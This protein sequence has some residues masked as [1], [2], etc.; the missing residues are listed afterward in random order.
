[1]DDVGEGLCPRLLFAQ[2]HTLEDRKYIQDY[3]DQT[4][5]LVLSIPE[6]QSIN[7]RKNVPIS[8]ESPQKIVRL[9]TIFYRD[10]SRKE[11]ILTDFPFT[12]DEFIELEN[13]NRKVSTY[14]D[15][16]TPDQY[17]FE[18]SYTPATY[19]LETDRLLKPNKNN[20][21]ASELS[22]KVDYWIVSGAIGSGKTTVAK[23]I[24]NEFGFKMIEFET[25]L[26]AAKE[27]LANPDEG[28]EVPLK[29]ILNYFKN[30]LVQNKGTTCI[31]DGLT[32]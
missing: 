20:C 30:L 25:E 12:L 29:K 10:L 2:C 8:L 31:I 5:G 7:K 1:M 16:S 19:F 23:H 32:Y 24:Q 15:L 22:E 3:V 18:K 27:K 9:T 4:D 11:I 17:R 28:E 21:L 6:I 14:I 26:A 13:A